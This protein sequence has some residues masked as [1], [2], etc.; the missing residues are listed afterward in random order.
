MRRGPALCQ[1]VNTPCAESLVCARAGWRNA[2]IIYD[3]GDDALIASKCELGL[4]KK[5]CTVK[6]VK[7]TIKRGEKVAQEKI[8][9]L[10][11]SGAWHKMWCNSNGNGVALRTYVKQPEVRPR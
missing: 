9:M 5:E 3:A 8:K 11:D 4:V 10:K 6:G 1:F 2:T 7:Y